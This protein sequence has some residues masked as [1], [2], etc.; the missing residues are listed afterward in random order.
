M[1]VCVYV[2]VSYGYLYV[3]F[4]LSVCDFVSVWQCAGCSSV[5][6]ACLCVSVCLVFVS[7]YVVECAFM[8]VWCVCQ[9]V[10]L[11]YSIAFHSCRIFTFGS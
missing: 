10:G 1:C 11:C 5:C 6:C 7:M 2:L 4:V 3:C 8:Y 9:S